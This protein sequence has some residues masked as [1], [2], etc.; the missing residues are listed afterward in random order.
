MCFSTS[1]RIVKTIHLISPTIVVLC[2]ADRCWEARM[3]KTKWGWYKIFRTKLGWN[4]LKSYAFFRKWVFL[5]K[6]VFTFYV[7]L[8]LQCSLEVTPGCMPSASFNPLLI[9]RREAY[10][11]YFSVLVFPL[12]LKNFL[13]TPLG[14]QRLRINK[15][16][17]WVWES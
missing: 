16:N 12:P 10:W 3:I 1:T 17:K 15:K 8:L 7:G 4:F 9:K 11:C 5:H 13:P 2:C 14:A 6:K